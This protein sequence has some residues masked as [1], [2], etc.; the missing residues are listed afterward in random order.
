LIILLR[1]SRNLSEHGLIPTLHADN[2]ISVSAMSVRETATSVTVLW[3]D[4]TTTTERTIDLILFINIDEYSCWP[5]DHVL[6]KGGEEGEKVAIVQKVSTER[7]AEIQ[8]IGAEAS[9]SFA[10]MRCYGS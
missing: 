5:G 9:S 2:T 1:P 10:P 3:Q 8:L 6:F 4:G 7:T